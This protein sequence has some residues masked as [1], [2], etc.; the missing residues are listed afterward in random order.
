MKFNKSLTLKLSKRQMEMELEFIFEK[1]TNDR[2]VILKQRSRALQ[3][4]KRDR[5]LLLFKI[6]QNK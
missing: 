1:T 3:T 6:S 5:K 2:A 4:A